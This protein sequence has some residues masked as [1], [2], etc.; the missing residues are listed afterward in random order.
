QL[1]RLDDAVDDES[2]TEAC[3]QTEEEHLAALVAAQRLHRRIVDDLDGTSEGGLVV[4]GDPTRP[5]IARLHD[6][7]TVEQGARVADRYGVVLPAPGD[8]L[9]AGHHLRGG[10]RGP[11]GKLPGRLLAS[12]ENLH[13]SAAHVDHQDAHRAPQLALARAALFAAI[14]LMSSCQEPTNDLAPS[15]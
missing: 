13:V 10:E 14:T 5:Q 7:R 2:R 6:R 9:D 11:G 1:H 3:S 4:E 8:G 15:S 12:G